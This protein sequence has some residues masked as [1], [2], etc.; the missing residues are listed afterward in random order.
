M[1]TSVLFHSDCFMYKRFRTVVSESLVSS[2]L[3]S[4]PAILH[5]GSASVDLEL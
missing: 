2:A 3:V 1:G 4:F 5:H